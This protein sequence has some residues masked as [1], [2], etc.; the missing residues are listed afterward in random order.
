MRG[1]ARSLVVVLLVAACSGG[2]ESSADTTSAAD[3]AITV[4]PDPAASTTPTTAPVAGDGDDAPPTTTASTD[5]GDDT[6]AGADETVPPTTAPLIDGIEPTIELLTAV[7]T[8]EIRPLLEWAPIDGATHYLATVYAPDGSPYWT[9]TGPA[10]SVP[11][12]GEPKLSD[13]VPGPS[14]VGGMTWGVVALDDALV[15]IASSARQPI[16]P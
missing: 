6:G 3:G 16:E 15:P 2:D 13:D 9:W 5:S 14:V 11:V 7:R 10:T 4:A 8:G 1:V 12:G